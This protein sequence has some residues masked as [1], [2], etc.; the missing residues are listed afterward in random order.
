M[1]VQTLSRNL[2]APAAL[3]ESVLA[4]L[5]YAD[6][7][8]FP[9]SAP[10]IHRYLHG[11][12]TTRA[13]LM[14]WLEFGHRANRLIRHQAGYYF[15]KGKEDILSV[16]QRRK[17]IASACLPRAFHYGNLLGSLPFVRMVALT[18]SLAVGNSD[19]GA[20]FDYF[21]ITSHGRLWLSRALVI[22]FVR[23]VFWR[24]KD[25]I[26]PNFIISEVA[27]EMPHRNIY[28]AHEIT[29]MV[30]IN[31]MEVYQRFRE[32]NSWTYSYLPNASGPPYSTFPLT[33]RKTRFRKG[34]ERLLSQPALDSLERWE[35]ERKIYRYLPQNSNADEI[36]FSPHWC[37]GHFNGHA[38]K[39]LNLYEQRL[40]Q[41]SA[42]IPEN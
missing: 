29:Q 21:I 14:E 17:L 4:T 8:D 31:G 12:Q 10:E 1:I 24:N 11:V 34:I 38:L 32:S 37:Q 20:D 2:T 25:T 5:A 27:M 36:H 6:L 35:M 33:S 28:T 26:C 9:L 16:R 41:L 18:G 42:Q 40:K 22:L 7:F 23:W 15:I 30:P 19:H 13:P 3:E 39:T